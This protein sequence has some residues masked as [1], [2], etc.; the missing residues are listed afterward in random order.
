MHRKNLLI[1]L[2]LLATGLA[3]QS[4]AL[5]KKPVDGGKAVVTKS[6]AKPAPAKDRKTQLRANYHFNT[7]EEHRRAKNYSAAVE[8][9]KK[10]IADVPDD[11]DFYKHLGGTYAQMGKLKEAEDA[12]RTGVKLDPK[13]WLLWNNLAVT[14]QMAGKNDECVA[15]LKKALTLHPPDSEAEKMKV[16]LDNLSSK[17]GPGKN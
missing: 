1:S 13:D 7:A 2:T 17:K 8:E 16:T 5:A 3:S 12:L 11:P 6:K 10:A 9:Y 14:L 15:A 4:P